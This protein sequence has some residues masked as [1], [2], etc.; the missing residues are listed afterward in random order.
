MGT[1]CEI[2]NQGYDVNRPVMYSNIT[3]T[4]HAATLLDEAGMAQILGLNPDLQFKDE[5]GGAPVG[6]TN[7]DP[8]AAGRKMPSDM[9]ISHTLDDCFR[10]R[11]AVSTAIEKQKVPASL[12][13]PIAADTRVQRFNASKARR[14]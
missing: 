3:L 8:A 13:A 10:L 9:I 12:E 4:M 11:R 1:V 14:Q 2:V 5:M 7:T 6:R